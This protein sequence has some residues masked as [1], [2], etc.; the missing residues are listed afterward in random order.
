MH[1]LLLQGSW[2]TRM[3]HISPKKRLALHVCT[4]A[5]GESLCMEQGGLDIVCRLAS[6][7]GLE[8]LREP[9]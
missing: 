2:V 3:A 8:L 6:V 4:A 5:S 1:I 9:R 7:C